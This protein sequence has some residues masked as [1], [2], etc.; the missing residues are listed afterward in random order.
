LILN[1][2]PSRSGPSRAGSPMSPPTAYEISDLVRR[3]IESQFGPN[4]RPVRIVIELIGAEPVALPIL[5]APAK[6]PSQH[7]N[8]EVAK[9]AGDE[10]RSVLWHGQVFGFSPAQAK[11]VEKL[12]GAR[13]NGNPDV[14]D[15]HLIRVSG[16]PDGR[17]DDLFHGSPAWGTLITDGDARG[18]HRI[19]PPAP[20]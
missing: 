9:S 13:A 2:F 19:S 14:P 11:V 20:E 18:T 8:V 3:W 5:G 17:L 16:S 6:A 10:F 7:S 12:W 15:D 4:I 1:R